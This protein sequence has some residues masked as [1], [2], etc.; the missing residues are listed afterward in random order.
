MTTP[1]PSAADRR[2]RTGTDPAATSHR[3]MLVVEDDAAALERIT[4]QLRSR[5]G[6]DY[7]V[8]GER[9]GAAGL[10]ALRTLRNENAQVAVVLCDRTG[11]GDTDEADFFGE[12]M[13]FYPEAKRGLL[14]DWGAWADRPTAELILRLMALGKI[15][16]YVLRPWRTPDE[17]F[18][19]TITEF[20]LEWERAAS[21]VPREVTVVGERWSR[22]SHELRSLLSRNGVPHVFHASDSPTGR[23]L[24]AEVGQS[25]AQAPVVLLHDGRVLVGPTNAELAA[26]YGVSTHLETDTNFD[27]IVVGAGPAGLAAAVYGSSEGLRTLVVERESIGGQAGSSSLIRNYLGFARGVSGADLAQRAYQQAWVFGTNFLL[28]REAVGLRS[29]GPWHVLT[30]ANSEQTRARA[31]VLATGVTYSRIDI[32]ALEA[33]VGAGVF[34]GA[35][36]SEARALAGQDVFVVGGG[37]SAG[38]AAMHLSRYARTVTL[39]VRGSS[40]AESMSE[41]LRQ[42]IEAA[43]IRVW[44]QTEV[45]DGG[46]DGRLEWITLRDRRSGET[47]TEPAAALFVLIGA[48]PHTDWLPPEIERDQWGYVRTGRDVAA[49]QVTSRWALPRPPLMHETC[50]PGIFAVGDVRRGSVKRVAS[51]VGEGSVVIAE[52]HELLAADQPAPGGARPPAPSA[53]GS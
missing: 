7:E 52:V 33:L 53:K 2:S 16:Y 44:L 32:P 15:D 26:G 34:Y 13:R 3:V 39:L 18:H 22:R 37:N 42:E 40:L 47:R 28:M 5:Y 17:Y 38:Q 10:A 27:L 46:G 24:L 30:T 8:V 23:R 6:N 21:V 31:V 4:D 9:S 41:Y 1:R 29:D 48:Q 25:G 49:G 51:A 36:V 12:V 50:V 20:L 14:V 19:R 45:V 11:S 43:G 35:S